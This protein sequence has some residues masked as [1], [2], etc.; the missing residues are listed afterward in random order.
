MTRTMLNESFVGYGYA[1][2]ATELHC[3]WYVERALFNCLSFW[4]GDSLC[5]MPVRQNS[6]IQ[7]RPTCIDHIV[8][9]YCGLRLKGGQIQLSRVFWGRQAH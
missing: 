9:T 4:F 1:P 6:V 3:Q 2:R 8:F 7:G 5:C